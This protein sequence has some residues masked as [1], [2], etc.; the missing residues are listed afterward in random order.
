MLTREPFE[1]RAARARAA[2]YGGKDPRVEPVFTVPPEPQPVVTKQGSPCEENNDGW[3]TAKAKQ[4]F[5]LAI[6]ISSPAVPEDVRAERMASCASCEHCTER[7][8]KHYC[9]CCGCP[10][11]NVGTVGSDLEYKTGKA[12][13]MCPRVAPAYGPWS[14]DGV[15][16]VR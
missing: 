13:W 1:A 12:A 2:H 3:L 10:R 5:S 9:E 4:A 11:W 14:S 7:D 6:V 8:G 15:S 16:M